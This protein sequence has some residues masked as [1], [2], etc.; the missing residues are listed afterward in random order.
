MECEKTRIED[1]GKVR[2]TVAL[3]C[4]SSWDKVQLPHVLSKLAMRYNIVQF[5]DETIQDAPE[6]FDAMAFINH[7]V[8]QSKSG[9]LP[10]HGVA[11]S[12][13][14]PG[15]LVAASIASE[16]KLPGCPMEAIFYCS[17][18]YYSRVI[19]QKFMPE[20]CPSFTIVAPTSKRVDEIPYPFFLKPVK[21][22]MSVLAC[23]IDSEQELVKRLE[24]H[25]T[26][27]HLTQYVRAFNQ[28]LRHYCPSMDLDGSYMLA[29]SLMSGYQVT[30]EGF[31]C[32]RKVIIIGIVDS[33]MHPGTISFKRFDYPSHLPQYVQDRMGDI[34][35]QFV[36]YIGMNNTFFNVE[37]FYCSEAPIGQD[38]K[39][40][41]INPRMC[42]QFADLYESVD[43]TNTYETLV[44]LAAGDKPQW[45]PRR[46][47]YKVAASFPLRMFKD[48]RI[49]YIPGVD[50]FQNI[51]QKWQHVTIARSFCNKIGQRLSELGHYD[52]VSYKYG[53]VNM[54]G[55]SL[56]TMLEEFQTINEEL[57]FKFE[58]IDEEN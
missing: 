25:S 29:E 51:M 56:K 5:G 20:I 52:G 34:C 11:S 4:A 43:G 26:Q 54:A 49:V 53:V 40:I 14:Y 9:K 44:S 1:S 18:K 33:I 50:K 41:E 10:I 13:D 47:I 45:T 27:T 31:I 55:H 17:H 12:S 37:M 16:L 22:V 6:E 2:K 35:T 46:G 48:A 42:G 39:I 57:G 19:Q 3:V 15:S 38:I 8:N 30:V 28:L 23:H 32:D 21:S 7:I 36:Q 24:Q 58:F